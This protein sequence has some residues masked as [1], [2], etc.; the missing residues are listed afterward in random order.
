MLFRSHG[1]SLKR[2]EFSDAKKLFDVTEVG[3]LL[4]KNPS[5]G[6]VKEVK[7]FA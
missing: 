6:T 2:L 7:R 3:I 5:P 4:T 1:D